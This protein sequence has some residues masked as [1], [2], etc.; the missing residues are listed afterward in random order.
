MK[1]KKAESLASAT[2]PPPPG[3][4]GVPLP[5]RRKIVFPR[6]AHAA[7]ATL[8]ARACVRRFYNAGS[9]LPITHL[10]LV[11]D[12]PPGLVA[13]CTGNCSTGRAYHALIFLFHHDMIYSSHGAKFPSDGN[14]ARPWCEISVR[15]KFREALRKENHVMALAGWG[16]ESKI[17]S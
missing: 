11:A 7:L 6:A 8:A 9:W 14:F 10:G 1:S 3:G 16:C 13:D 12:H 4:G 15:R 5:A 2:Y 17:M